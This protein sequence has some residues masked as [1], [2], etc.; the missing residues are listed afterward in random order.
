V[1]MKDLFSLLLFGYSIDIYKS[2]F[3]DLL[4]INPN[5]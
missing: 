3:Q 1:Y 5:P 2:K 4:G